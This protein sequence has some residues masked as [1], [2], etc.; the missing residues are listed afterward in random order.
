MPNHQLMRDEIDRGDIG[1]AVGLSETQTGDTICDEEHPIVLEAIEFPSPVIS[2]SITPA[3]RADQERL[4]KALH[5]MSGEDPDVRRVAQRGDEGDG[6][7]RDGGIAPGDHRRPDAAGVRGGGEGGDA[8]GGVPGDDHAH[9]GALAQAREAD[10]GARA[11]RA[12][13]HPDG[14]AGA[15]RGVRV[16]G[17]DPRRG[18]PDQLHPGS[19]A[20][21]RGRD[22]ERTV[23]GVPG[24]GRAGD[25]VRRDVPRGGFERH[26]VPDVRE[27]RRSGRR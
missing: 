3:S 27:R 17:Q 8:A 6:D 15:G 16:R 2:V 25:A 9:G 10:G 26:R 11:I 1:A 5:A 24:G 12:R 22:G 4:G 23:R 20:G 19:G 21:D 13:V 18:D 7:Q 14:A